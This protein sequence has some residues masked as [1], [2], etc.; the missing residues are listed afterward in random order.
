MTTTAEFLAALFGQEEAGWVN[1]LRQHPATDDAPTRMEVLWAP[2]GEAATA[3]A[4]LP[5]GIDTWV[6]CATRLANTGSQRGGVAACYRVPALWV[7][8][9]WDHPV[10]A[11]EPGTLC[12]DLN[13]ALQ[14]LG[15]FVIAP[16]YVV[17]SGHGLQAWYVLTEALEAQEYN[18]EWRARW[19]ATW[20]R[21]GAQ[22]GVHVDPVF[23]VDRVM[24]LPGTQNVKQGSCGPMVEIL[25]QQGPTWGLEELDDLLDPEPEAPAALTLVAPTTYTGPLRP[26]DDFNARESCDTILQAQGW[27]Q[28]R[29]TGTSGSH[30]WARPGK[31][32]GGAS[33]EVHAD[34]YVQV[35]STTAHERWPALYDA[36]SGRPRML[37]PFGLLAAWAFDGDTRA[38][39]THLATLGY[40]TPMAELEA[41]RERQQE[42]LRSVGSSSATVLTFPAPADPRAS[43]PS[44]GTAMVATQD[45]APSSWAPHDLVALR[46][47]PDRPKPLPT[48][49]PVAGAGVGLLYPA[50]VHMFVGASES[51]KTWLALL[52]ARGVV[53]D[54]GRVLILDFEDDEGTAVERLTALGLS[55]VELGLITY[56]RPE[57]PVFTIRGGQPVP[58]G[59]WERLWALVV[60]QTL[61][62]VDGINEALA[63]H[64][65]NMNQATEVAHLY[66]YLLRPMA[67]RYGAAVVGIDHV[68]KGDGAEAAIGSQ[69]KRS[70][71]DVMLRLDKKRPF[72]KG[73]EGMAEIVISKDR[74]GS[75]R[76]VCAD[77]KK[78]MLATFRLASTPFGHTVSTVLTKYEATTAQPME[79]GTGA[80]SSPLVA[81]VLAYI[82]AHA[83]CNARDL[84][85]DLGGNA[86]GLGDAVAELVALGAVLRSPGPRNSTLLR[87]TE[88]GPVIEGASEASEGALE[89]PGEVVELPPWAYDSSRSEVE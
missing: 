81:S 6:G 43:H 9:D 71:C 40:G 3:F 39:T 16:T 7:D 83:G 19:T 49:A 82:Q 20:E 25:P 79:N 36:R 41:Y 66:S 89:A 68:A 24:R 60:H 4:A 74:P 69:H 58:T 17:N 77:Y 59:D 26:G 46:N 63:M 30:L 22:A 35:Y 76:A 88:V 34:G 50:K 78:E 5:A 8:M 47:N 13:H 61:V 12:R 53:R 56:V 86:V 64:G 29:R 75:L 33:A 10:H 67:K 44:A 54:G 27:V 32:D 15:M 14:V 11:A 87:A 57:T 18:E 38:C 62:V 2:V 31:E 85:R 52:A 37:D 65:L 45:D 84:R 42:W 55:D 80:F 21:V 72:A 73:S 48:I 28:L 70:A 23:N 1:V 51:G